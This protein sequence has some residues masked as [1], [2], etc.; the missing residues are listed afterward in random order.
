MLSM[1]VIES[2]YITHTHYIIFAVHYITHDI[3]LQSFP[4]VRV[5]TAAVSKHVLQMFWM[6]LETECMAL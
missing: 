6:N 4:G 3:T 1:T 5:T 2:C